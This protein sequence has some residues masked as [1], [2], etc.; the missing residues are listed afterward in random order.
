MVTGKYRFYSTAVEWIIKYI[1]SY[2]DLQLGPLYYTV[3]ILP[4]LR[5][6]HYLF[7]TY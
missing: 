5:K 1:V 3:Q 4:I 6:A 7:I 2:K